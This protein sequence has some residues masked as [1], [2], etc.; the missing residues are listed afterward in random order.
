MDKNFCFCYKPNIEHKGGRFGS[1]PSTE[2][3]QCHTCGRKSCLFYYAGNY[4][5][6][7]GE[8]R[9]LGLDFAIPYLDRVWVPHVKAIAEQR[10]AQEALEVQTFVDKVMLPLWPDLKLYDRKNP[11]PETGYSYWTEEQKRLYDA[12]FGRMTSEYGRYL[13]L[14]AHLDYTKKQVPP[15]IP[16]TGLYFFWDIEEKRY[17][18][19]NSSP[20][21]EI[22]QAKKAFPDPALLRNEQVFQRLFEAVPVPAATIQDIPSQYM[23]GGVPW[24]SIS[25]KGHTIQVGRRR[26]VWELKCTPLISAEIIRAVAIQKDSTVQIDP[27]YVLVHAW[28]EEDLQFYFREMVASIRREQ[29]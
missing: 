18:R 17:Q 10:Y 12:V 28:N 19:A 16:V 1:L 14:P 23:E 6:V 5:L 21:F 26:R 13:P 22:S 3:M 8:Q 2:Q 20:W 25:L 24:K 11:Q 15:Q 4:L 27:E 9:N 7:M 29:T